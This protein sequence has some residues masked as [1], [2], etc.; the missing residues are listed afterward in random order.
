MTNHI[1][2]ASKKLETVINDMVKGQSRDGMQLHQVST[3]LLGLFAFHT[4]YWINQIV[5]T[6]DGRKEMQAIFDEML[7]KA[8]LSEPQFEGEDDICSEH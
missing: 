8:I 3:D 5:P 6:A 7:S 1:D 4:A 2:I